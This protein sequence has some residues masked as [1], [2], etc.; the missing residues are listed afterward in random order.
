MIRERTARRSNMLRKFVKEDLL[1][2]L[3]KDIKNGGDGYA[4]VKA[5]DEIRHLFAAPLDHN[6]G[7]PYTNKGPY[8]NV[9]R[10]LDGWAASEN[11]SINVG[12]AFDN[13]QRGGTP[14]DMRPWGGYLRIALP[15]PVVPVK[16]TPPAPR[17]VENGA[18]ITMNEMLVGI[19]A[20]VIITFLLTYFSIRH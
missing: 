2:A 16:P 18:T 13:G 15:K 9:W 7:S 11:L 4:R 14:W 8:F 5:P 17:M 6:G 20:S 12:E 3:E 10:E 1:A 19:F